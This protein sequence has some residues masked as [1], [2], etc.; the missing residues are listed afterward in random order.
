MIEKF[1]NVRL[2]MVTLLLSLGTL[3]GCGPD[4]PPLG[5]VSG[6]VTH[7]GEPLAQGTIT[8]EVPGARPARGEIVDGKIVNLS[9]YE[10]GDGV[11]VGAASV[12]ITSTVQ[13]STVT[14]PSASDDAPG[15]PSGMP[16][17]KSLIPQEYANP[18]SSGLTATIEEGENAL[19]FDL[20]TK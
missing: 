2:V 3:T 15:G 13:T 7:D 18:Q 5:D 20:V 16:E 11:P 4:R 1:S 9:T 17:Y 10:A 12:A 14:E 8:F 6:T 19:S